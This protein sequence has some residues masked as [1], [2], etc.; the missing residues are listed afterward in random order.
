M[1]NGSKFANELHF[2]VKGHLIPQAYSQSDIEHM[3]GQYIKRLWGNH[4]RLPS[5]LERFEKAWR[6]ANGQEEVKD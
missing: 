1:P 2:A 3:E 5:S 4:E 6:T